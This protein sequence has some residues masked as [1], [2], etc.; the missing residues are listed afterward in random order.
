M[1]H[2]ENDVIT[3]DRI[4]DTAEVLFA[5]KGFHAVSV[6][7]ITSAAGCNLASINYHFGNKDNLYLEVFRAR[8]LPR[9]HRLRMSFRQILEKKPPRTPADLVEAMARA[10]IQGPLTDEERRRH[11]Q[12][13]SK[14][15][16]KPSEAFE[17]VVEQVMKPFLL[18]YGR[19]LQSILPRPLSEE[20]LM[21]SLFSILA[22]VLHFSFA[23]PVITR[24]TGR[25]YNDEFKSQLVD[26][27]TRFSL[28][29]IEGQ[30][31]EAR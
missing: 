8:V 17:L 23:S 2:V 21:L 22:M 5:E 11:A 26:H 28:H 14:E 30:I 16:G 13:M 18:D 25:S 12:L 6:R 4:L 15:M 19:L 7:E 24:I 3:K 31:E 1:S 10:F 9:A 20:R 29:G 27:I